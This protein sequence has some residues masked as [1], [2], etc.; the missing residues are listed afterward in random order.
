MPDK[1]GRVPLLAIDDDPATLEIIQDALSDAD[2]D[3]HTTMDP[4]EGLEVFHTVRPRIVLVDL[5]MPV[6]TGMD[7]LERMLSK[8]PGVEVI[9]MTGH[10]SADSAVEAIQK[11]AR[12]YLAKPLNLAK[13]RS[14]ISDL[15]DEVKQKET[16]FQLDRQLIEA[17]QFEGMIGRSPLMLEVFARIRRVAPHF[18]TVLITG[19]TGTGKELVAKALHR[20]RNS[21]SGPFAVC[22]CAAVVDT[23]F[24][25]ELFGYVKGAFTGATE[26]KI[27]LFEYANRG[28]VFLDEIGEM[29]LSAQAKLLR[30]LQEHEVHRVGSP[31]PRKV[32]VRVIAA[33][34]RDLPSLI[35]EGKFR[36]DLFYRLGMVE[37]SL[38]RLENRKEDLPLLERFMVEK[39]AKQ[40][41]K[42][43]NGITRRAQTC[44]SAYPWPGNI[45]ELE[46]ALSLAVM[47]TEN[48]LIDLNDLPKSLLANNPE[49]VTKNHNLVTFEELQHLHLQRVLEYVEGDK[50]RAAEILGISRSTLY[51]L[52][53]RI[54]A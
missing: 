53:G 35:K 15:L 8:D 13:L 24:E 22:N 29:P 1:H 34:N 26:D 10:Y 41:G 7:L 18:Q 39:Y 16:A 48:N 25:S 50:T 19:Q 46:N 30:V 37:I 51:N 27:G 17:F 23:L 49:L 36:E 52:L 43:I 21:G 45:R 31:V 2:V 14:R 3:V 44:L 11:G 6:L 38:P 42:K 54:K 4:E 12:D 9:L 32:D 28:T 40:Y 33:T 5:M 20:L 47:M